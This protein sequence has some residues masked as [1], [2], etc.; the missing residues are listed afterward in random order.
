LENLRTVLTRPGFTGSEIQVLRGVISCLDR[1]SFDNPRG[2]ADV[3]RARKPR[4]KPR[5]NRAER[6]EKTEE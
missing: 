5:A 3:N 6:N 2:G 4:V 1:F